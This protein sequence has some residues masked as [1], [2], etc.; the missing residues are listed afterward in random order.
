MTA[1]V[2]AFPAPRP[3]PVPTPVRVPDDEPLLPRLERVLALLKAQ[4]GESP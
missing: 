1:E 2:I 4:R 3:K